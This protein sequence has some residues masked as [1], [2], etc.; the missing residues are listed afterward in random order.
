MSMTNK[1]DIIWNRTRDLPACSSVPQPTA[2]HKTTYK[3]YSLLQLNIVLWWLV[4]KPLLQRTDIC[5]CQNLFGSAC[6]PPFLW[7][8]PAS[9]RVLRPEMSSGLPLPHRLLVP[10]HAHP[11][12]LILFGMSKLLLFSLRFLFKGPFFHDNDVAPQIIARRSERLVTV[13][14]FRRSSAAE[15][16]A[17]QTLAVA[18][19]RYQ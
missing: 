6:R 4:F 11:S 3:C 17:L 5:K 2:P 18:T 1:N 16:E 12:S 19:P 7:W 10:E 15:T 14:V 9:S 13:G 8:P